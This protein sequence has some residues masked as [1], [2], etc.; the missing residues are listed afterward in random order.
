MASMPII[1][2]LNTNKTQQI[3]P[4]ILITAIPRL[5][6]DIF[7]IIR[8]YLKIVAI[9]QATKCYAIKKILYL[10]KLSYT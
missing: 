2:A 5:F 3:R 1:T 10:S 7:T 4:K 6:I 9:F 8:P